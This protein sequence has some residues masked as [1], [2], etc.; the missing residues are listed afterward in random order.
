[1]IHV[2]LLEFLRTGRF[3]PTG[4]GVSREA[5]AQAF[6]PPDDRD[7]G[8][9]SDGVARIWRY[10][11]VELHFARGPSPLH[12]VHAEHFAVPGGGPRIELDPWIVSGQLRRDDAQRWLSGAG[13]AFTLRPLAFWPDL[14][15][16]RTS[17]G[18]SLTFE[19]EDGTCPGERR[20]VSMSRSE[21][22]TL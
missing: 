4:L 10:G 5:V 22:A 21:R 18:V 19:G 7:A 6:G 12:L 14:D 13:I 9:A 16:L 15:E 20:L 1:V 2:S 11:D 17:S 8:S 3:G